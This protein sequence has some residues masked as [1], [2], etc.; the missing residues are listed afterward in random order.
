MS[1]VAGL[2]MGL[3]EASCPGP[4]PWDRM[5]GA[6]LDTSALSNAVSVFSQRSLRPVFAAVLGGH[7]AE[8]TFCFPEKKRESQRRAVAYPE[9]PVC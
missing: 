3:R 6:Q 4:D 7:Q 1:P 8:V 9:P 5:P 2:L